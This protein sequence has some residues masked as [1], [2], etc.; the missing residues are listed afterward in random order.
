MIHPT[1]FCSDGGNKYIYFPAKQMT[2]LAH[3][4]LVRLIE[5]YYEKVDVFA[6]F[7]TLLDRTESLREYGIFSLQEAEYH[8]KLFNTLYENGFLAE[9]QPAKKHVFRLTPDV[10]K[11]EFANLSHVLLEL[12]QRCNLNCS[13]CGYGKMYDKFESRNGKSLSFECACAIIDFVVSRAKSH[14]RASCKR[15]IEIT[16]YGGEPLLEFEL[17]ERIVAYTKQHSQQ[18]PFTFSI[19]TNGILLSRYMHFLKKHDF[20]ISVSLDGNAYH[21]SFRKDQAGSEVHQ[22]IIKEVSIIRKNYPKYYQDKVSFNSVL[23]DRNPLDEV[24]NYFTKELDKVPMFSPIAPNG[25]SALGKSS[26]RRLHRDYSFREEGAENPDLAFPRLPEHAQLIDIVHHST[27][28]VYQDYNDLEFLKNDRSKLPSG[29]CLPFSLKLFIT[30]LGNILP[31]EKVSHAFILGYVDKEGVHLNY[32]K[33]AAEYNSYFSAILGQC[34]SCWKYE[35]CSSCILKLSDDGL[36]FK[37]PEQL[38]LD[39]MSRFLAWGLSYIE[40]S[41]KIYGRIMQELVYLKG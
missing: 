18:L 6:W 17:L 36:N 2:L 37:C 29:T 19:V 40:K 4:L 38:D 23:H 15:P 24:I 13:Y 27:P 32:E 21:N 3:P 16:F 20:S 34:N 33:I 9:I 1:V 10:I 7:K 30:S 28:F 26:F 14:L 5:H 8:I 22:Q 39:G 12:T 11:R 41:P 35:H 31:C 25:L